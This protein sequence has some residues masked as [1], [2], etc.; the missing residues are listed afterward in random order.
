LKNSLQLPQEIIMTKS[1]CYPQQ[2][3]QRNLWLAYK[4]KL[5]R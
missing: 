1:T 4:I 5:L 2:F 3:Y